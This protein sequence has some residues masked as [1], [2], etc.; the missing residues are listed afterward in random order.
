M[1]YSPNIDRTGRIVRAVWG[2][3]MLVLAGFTWSHSLLGAIVLGL[4]GILGL[5]QAKRGWCVARACG[6]KTR[7]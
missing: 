6:L 1:S 4:L 7:W 3:L 5:W 2:V